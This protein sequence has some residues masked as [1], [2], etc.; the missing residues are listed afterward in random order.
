MSSTVKCFQL[1]RAKQALQQADPVMA[2]L[3]ELVGRT[4]VRSE[5]QMS[6]FQSLTRAVAFQ[7]ISTKAATAI[8]S[9]LE[10]ACGQ[11]ISPAHVMLLGED[12]LRLLGYSRAKCASLLDLAEKFHS[13]E[14]PADSI[15]KKMPDDKLVK[16]LTQVRGIGKWSVEM[17][18]IFNLRRADV[19]PAT[20]LGVRKGHMYAYG[21]EEML[22]P[23][24]LIAC[25]RLWMPNRSVATWYL[26]RS[27]DSVDWSSVNGAKT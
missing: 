23:K 9:R 21:L 3:I 22:E 18:M 7:M 25:S 2:R 14:I 17:L 20:D 8:H 10:D 15:L 26:W 19:F 16:C 27:T 6:V 4:R 24:E 1:S 11:D 12:K 13:G 5:K